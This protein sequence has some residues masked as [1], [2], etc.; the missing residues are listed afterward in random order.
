M[1]NQQVP[2][3]KQS[4]GEILGIVSLCLSIFI[5]SIGVVCHVIP[6]P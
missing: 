2:T 6:I 3:K 5:F 4:L 1:E